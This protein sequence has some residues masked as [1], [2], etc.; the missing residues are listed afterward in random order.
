MTC[1]ASQKFDLARAGE[2]EIQSRIALAGYEACHELSACLLR[3]ALG[4]GSSAQ[5]LVVGAGGGAFEII[6]AGKLEPE[7]GFTAVD[8]SQPMMAISIRR[9]E[10]AGMIPRTQVCIGQVE[11]LPMDQRFDAATLIGVLH[12][13]PGDGAKLSLLNSLFERLKPGAPLILA[14]NRNSYASQPLLLAAWAE[15]WRM[16]GASAAEVEVKQSKILQGADP[17]KSDAA[18]VSLLAQAGF[19]RAT[20]FFSNLFWGAWL[21]FRTGDNS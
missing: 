10:E 16:Y 9:L 14:G 20:L 11:D 5:I 8:P 17:P 18:V 6:T 19:E 3:V 4:T 1:I 7:W 12:H 2:Y 13:Q 15:R 21:A